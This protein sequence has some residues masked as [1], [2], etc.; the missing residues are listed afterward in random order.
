M[1]IRPL[2]EGDIPTCAQ[3]VTTAPVWQRYGLTIE[4]ATQ[5]FS[6]ALRTNAPVL[7]ADDGNGNVIGFVRL[8]LRGAFDLSPY[9]RWLAV[10]STQRSRGV[11]R[12]LLS[13]AEALVQP[14]VRDMFLLCADF[15]TDAQRFYESN[16][17]S[18]IGT[19]PDYVIPGVT[20]YIY[21]KRLIP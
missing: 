5:Q 12:Q 20:E 3:I 13:G 16:G 21:R 18:R 11:G 19:I 9:I 4:R 15:N 17:Y 7:V 8:I 6:E 1:F 10:A 2:T 14:P